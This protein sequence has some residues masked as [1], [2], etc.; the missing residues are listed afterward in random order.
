MLGELKCQSDPQAL[1]VSRQSQSLASSSSRQN[2]WSL[3]DFWAISS[4]RSWTLDGRTP[5]QEMRE[6]KSLLCLLESQCGA[7]T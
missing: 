2:T 6:G 1:A 4:Q 3:L 7:V 5:Q